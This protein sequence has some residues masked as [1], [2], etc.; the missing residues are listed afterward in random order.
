MAADLALL[1]AIQELQLHLQGLT[2]EGNATEA[3][4][5]GLRDALAAAEQSAADAQEELSRLPA[6]AA[7]FRDELGALVASKAAVGGVLRAAR[8]AA[9]ACAV[10]AFAPLA[11]ALSGLVAAAAPVGELGAHGFEDALRALRAEL[12]AD[13]GAL[14]DLE[15]EVAATLEAARQAQER[16]DAEQAHA[17]DLGEQRR[18]SG[19]RVEAIKAATSRDLRAFRAAQEAASARRAA[20]EAARA[21]VAQLQKAIEEAQQQ[22]DVVRGRRDALQAQLA[23][24]T[25]ARGAQ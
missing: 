12:D 23:A 13:A 11:G 8:D 4:C 10:D 16:A 18:A 7:A 5:G 21:K 6:A 14:A 22:R 17:R 24:L 20:A 15:R 3:A 2:A 19:E 25:T 9:A 1:H